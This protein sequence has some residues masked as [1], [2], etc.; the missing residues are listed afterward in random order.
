MSVLPSGK[1]PLS[2]DLLPLHVRSAGQQPAPLL[3]GSLH[4]DCA[5]PAVK[6]ALF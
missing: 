6:G 1:Q 2:G 5:A 4:P 3:T